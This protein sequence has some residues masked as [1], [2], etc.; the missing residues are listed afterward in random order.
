[1]H[2]TESPHPGLPLVLVLPI[3]HQGLLLGNVDKGGLAGPHAYNLLWSICTN[4]KPL[5]KKRWPVYDHLAIRRVELQEGRKEIKEES[6]VI[7]SVRLLGLK[8]CN[9]SFK[10]I[11]ECRYE[12]PTMSKVMPF[13]GTSTKLKSQGASMQSV[14]FEYI[15]EASQGACLRLAKFFLHFSLADPVVIRQFDEPAQN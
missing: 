5:T 6:K 15:I 4:L 8:Q 14:C 3:L 1:M 9:C 2:K 7:L 10:G 11:N 13:E 12:L